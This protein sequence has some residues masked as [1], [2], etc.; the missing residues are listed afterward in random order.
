MSLMDYMGLPIQESLPLVADK[1]A[2]HDLKDRIKLI[3]S[4]K[5]ITPLLPCPHRYKKPSS[6][7]AGGTVRRT[8]ET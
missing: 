4:E 6:G 2:E 1:L 7:F 5:L 3:A 8:I